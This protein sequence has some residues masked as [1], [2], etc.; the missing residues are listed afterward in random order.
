MGMFENVKSA[1]D[2]LRGVKNV[3]KQPQSGARPVRIGS[4]PEA[5]DDDISILSSSFEFYRNW[6]SLEPDRLSIYSD[7]DDMGCYVLFASALDAYVEDATQPDFKTSKIVTVHSNNPDVQMIL[8]RLLETL[9]IDDRIYGD[10]WHTAKYGDYFNLLLVDQDKGVFD[11]CPLEPRIVWR[12]EDARRVLKGFSIGDA[13]ENS[14]DAKNDVPRY[15]PWDVIHWRLRSKRI[16]DP[17]G[18]P[19]FFHVRMIYKMLKLMEEQ[20]VMYRM[21]MHP[22]R[23]IFKVFTGAAGVEERRRVVRT[24]RREM[25]K[26]MSI[27]R[28]TGVMRAEYAPWMINQ[29][30]YWPVGAGDDKSGVE[31]FTGSANAGDILDVHYLRDLFFAG[32]RIPK[33]YM[34][35]EDSQGYRGTDTL[36]SQSIKFARGVKRL[37]RYQLQGLIRLCK[38]HLATQR[39]DAREA[40][41]QFSLEMS[42]TSYLDEAHKAELYAKRYESLNYMLDI[43]AKMAGELGINKQTWAKYV[44]KEFG[45]WD[46]D[47]IA[48]FMAP[49]GTDPDATYIPK[50]SALTFEQKE[51]VEDRVMNDPKL[52]SAKETISLAEAAAVVQRSQDVPTDLPKTKKDVK[53]ML[54]GNKK[55]YERGR[56][57][58]SQHRVKI[59][60]EAKERAAERKQ[61]LLQLA[62]VWQSEGR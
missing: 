58:D 4:P 21:N 57:L 38:I 22:D 24:W 32:V 28:N 44:L 30:I 11:S 26:H 31:K 35:F 19:F 59:D 37:Q 27:D 56:E 60:L 61:K 47:T 48:Q 18:M 12:H 15:K 14:S 50:D 34:G 2:I 62:K 9:E 51:Q 6:T 53:E 42:P 39:I 54:R 8:D 13:S 43:G 3:T 36:S 49:S 52:L 33:A 45:G 55:L 40:R 29:N 10:M 46:D 25:E 17:Y 1:W 5:P 7:M 16:D 23:L 20:M 41:N